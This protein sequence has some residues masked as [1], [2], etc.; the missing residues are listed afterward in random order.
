MARRNEVQPQ[1]I[2]DKSVTIKGNKRV[3]TRMFLICGNERAS[4]I[5]LGQ[6]Y[7]LQ[8]FLFWVFVVVVV[9]VVVLVCF[10]S[11]QDPNLVDFLLLLLL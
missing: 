10:S 3:E 5:S 7:K 9:V 1:C 11:N 6:S 4:S 2:S 8:R